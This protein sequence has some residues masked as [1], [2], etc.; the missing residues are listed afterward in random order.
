MERNKIFRVI[1][2]GLVFAAAAF[3]DVIVAVGDVEYIKLDL[4]EVNHSLNAMTN[5]G[6]Y[7]TG[8]EYLSLNGG[9]P[10]TIANGTDGAFNIWHSV[11]DYD[12]HL[13]SFSVAQYGIIAKVHTFINIWWGSA[14]ANIGT[15]TFTGS[16][17]AVYSVDFVVGQNV[18]DHFQGDFVNHILSP[19]TSLAYSPGSGV[20]LDRQEF[21]LPQEFSTQALTSIT[22]T[23][24]NFGDNYAGK[25]FLTAVT[26]ERAVPEPMTI[27]LFGIGIL[28]LRRRK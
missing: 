14:N 18:R 25:I 13:T 7:G 23:D 24:T 17:G 4:P 26:L 21:V 9:V 3:G 20:I 10:F 12:D 15:I 28:S 19:T 16:A 5:G 8:G 27:A 11:Y 6:S 2:V 22:V 1:C